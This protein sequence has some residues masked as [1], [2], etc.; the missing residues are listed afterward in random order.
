MSNDFHTKFMV[1]TNKNASSKSTKTGPRDDNIFISFQY[2]DVVRKYIGQESCNVS[3]NT[4]KIF[5]S[6]GMDNHNTCIHAIG[7]ILSIP[8]DNLFIRNMENSIQSSN[9]RI[10]KMTMAKLNESMNLA[11]MSINFLLCI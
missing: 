7:H 6:V 5:R 9:R 1:S 3:T 2:G 11:F 4:F 10:K 8:F